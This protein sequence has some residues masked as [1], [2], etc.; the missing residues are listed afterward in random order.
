MINLER[1]ADP[2]DVVKWVKA[3]AGEDA[4]VGIDAPIVIPNATGMRTADRLAQA[5]YGKFHAGAYPASRARSFWQRTTRL[6]SALV[7]LGFRHGDE[8]ATKSRGRFQIE[9]HPHA[10]SVQLFA[11]GRIVKYKKGTLSERATGLRELRTLM[12]ER[13]PHVIPRAL[14]ERLPAVPAKGPALKAIEDQLDAVLCAYIAAYWWYWGRE[15]N[16][17]LGNAKRGYIIV[18]CRQ[19]P[20]LKLADLREEYRDS[21]LEESHLEPDPL[22]QFQKWFTAARASGVSEPNAMTLATVAADGQPSARMVLLKEVTDAGFVFYTNYRSRKG[23]ELAANPRAALVFFWKEL[24]RQVRVTGDVVKTSRKDSEAYFG[25]RPRG[26]QLAAWASWQS[27][28]ISDREVLDSRLR[29]LEEKYAGS[30]L[31]LPPSWGGFRLKPD[32]IEF[33]QGRPDRLHDRFQY[34]KNS[35][36]NWKIE[37]LSP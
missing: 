26:A 5:M 25:S 13:L 12:L 23:R 34:S 17:V 21:P 35:R 14:F 18:P 33:W 30:S 16:E 27:S 32:T 6:S 37:R 36:G 20:D 2:D 9:V 31:P 3:Q 10:A 24:A 29:R 8:L 15:R 28:P 19:T 7:R 1:L 11:L 4:V 22:I